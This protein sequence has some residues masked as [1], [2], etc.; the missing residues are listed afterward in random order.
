MVWKLFQTKEAQ[1]APQ[2]RG[3]SGMVVHL[4]AFLS[5]LAPGFGAGSSGGSAV[6]GV[7]AAAA[8]LG[9]IGGEDGLVI[10]GQRLGWSDLGCIAVEPQRQLKEA[11]ERARVASERLL[12]QHHEEHLPALISSSCGRP[13]SP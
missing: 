6:A 4:G 2:Q 5:E 3:K 7:I 10:G 11:I 9:H 13:P 12:P 1:V 8:N